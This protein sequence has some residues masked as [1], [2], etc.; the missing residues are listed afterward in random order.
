MQVRTQ[1]EQYLVLKKNQLYTYCYQPNE[2]HGNDFALDGFRNRKNRKLYRKK[3]KSLQPMG[4]TCGPF[5]E[6]T[7]IKSQYFYIVFFKKL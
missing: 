1:S 4:L 7:N 5:F 3:L 6:L 2:N